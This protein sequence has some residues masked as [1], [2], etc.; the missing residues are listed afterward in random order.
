VLFFED[1][2]LTAQEVAT[3]L[4]AMAELYPYEEDEGLQKTGRQWL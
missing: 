1:D 4:H 3:I 2:T